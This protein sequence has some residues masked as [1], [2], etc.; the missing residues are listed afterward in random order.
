MPFV[1]PVRGTLLER[2]EVNGRAG[3]VSPIG[4]LAEDMGADAFGL[5]SRLNVEMLEV[6]TV[7]R[8]TKRVE[9]DAV[10]IQE[11][12]IGVCRIEGALQS[13]TSALDTEATETFEGLAHG[14]DSNLE[15]V[16]EVPGVTTSE[17]HTP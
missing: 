12:E 1:E 13:L 6:K 14:G 9:A 5:V 15:E 8:G 17:G 4:E 3:F 2:A 7:G 11:D 10:S 16:F